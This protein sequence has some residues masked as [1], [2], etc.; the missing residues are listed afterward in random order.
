MQMLPFYAN[1]GKRLDRRVD[2]VTYLRYPV[3]THVVSENDVLEEIVSQYVSPFLEKGDIVGLS[4]RCVAI[5]QGRSYLIKDIHPS[6]WAQFLSKFVTRRAGGIGLGSPWTME[7]ALREVG[8]FRILLASAVAALTRPFGLKGIFY[9]IAGGDINAIDGPC[10]YSLP[11]GDKSAKLGPKDPMGV[12][13]R[14]AQK[15]HVP[16]VIVD[17]N[18]F[19]VRVMGYSPGIMPS[20]IEKI[21]TDNPLGQSTEQTPIALIRKK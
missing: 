6:R 10:S 19:G 16:I 18:D 8:L 12:T 2:G 17:A 7:L 1:K 21:F 3:K 9:T 14:L 4:E 13:R 20:H 11:P 15:F 5:T